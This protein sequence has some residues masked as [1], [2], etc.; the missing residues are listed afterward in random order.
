MLAATHSDLAPWTCVR[1][2]HKKKAHK[3]VLRHVLRSLDEPA[4]AAAVEAP[5]D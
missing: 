4:S 5:V 3:A 2:N 1:A